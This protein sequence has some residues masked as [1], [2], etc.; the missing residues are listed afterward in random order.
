MYDVDKAASERLYHPWLEAHR[1]SA[2]ATDSQCAAVRRCDPGTYRI[3]PSHGRWIEPF[4]EAASIF[5]S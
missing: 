1:P 4:T 3:A 5:H 2:E